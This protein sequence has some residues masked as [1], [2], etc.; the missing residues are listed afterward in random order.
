MVDT[1]LPR[2]RHPVFLLAS[3]FRIEDDLNGN[4]ERSAPSKKVFS[5]SGM[6]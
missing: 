5:R 6:I 3:V 1:V 4:L 2:I